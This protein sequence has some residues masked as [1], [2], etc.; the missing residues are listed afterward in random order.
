VHRPNARQSESATRKII[1]VGLA[2]AATVQSA[3]ASEWTAKSIA[4]TYAVLELYDLKCG[5]LTSAARQATNKLSLM[6]DAG[7]L[8]TAALNAQSQMN[9]YGQDK[10]C[11][12]FAPDVKKFEAE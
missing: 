11:A 5:G 8:K 6:V 2:V 12:V 7:E 3:Q 4:E 1:F 9:D 10:W